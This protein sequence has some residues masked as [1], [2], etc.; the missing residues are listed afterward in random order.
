MYTLRGET[1]EPP[2]PPTPTIV[3]LS[4]NSK[5]DEYILDYKISTGTE[6]GVADIAYNHAPYNVVSGWCKFIGYHTANFNQKWFLGC[7]KGGS[8]NPGT[9]FGNSGDATIE[10]SG[11]NFESY[12]RN[13]R[14]LWKYSTT[15]LLGVYETSGDWE[16]GTLINSALRGAQTWTNLI[17]QNIQIGH[18]TYQSDDFGYVNFTFYGLRIYSDSSENGTLLAEY[19]PMIQN[20][21][22]GIKNTISGNFITKTA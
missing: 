18:I 11:Y 17:G 16:E 19:V 3:P 20:N 22:H 12:F 5:D 9:Q 8:I 13:V 15:G 6:L 4:I 7:Y 14:M 10:L 21:V 2:V 1:P